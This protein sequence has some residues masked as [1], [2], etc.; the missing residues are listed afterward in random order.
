MRSLCKELI[1][2][3]L[4]FVMQQF[5]ELEPVAEL[6]EDSGAGEDSSTPS[7]SPS[8]SPSPQPYHGDMWA[9]VS[10]PIYMYIIG[11]CLMTVCVMRD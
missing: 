2:S 10:R 3:E 7:G 6:E 8:P 4:L 5:M 1:K 9:E 11:Y